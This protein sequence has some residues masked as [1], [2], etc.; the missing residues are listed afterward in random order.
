MATPPPSDDCSTSGKALR[1]QLSGGAKP[2]TPPRDTGVR[3]W[4]KCIVEHR[5]EP[6]SITWPGSPEYPDLTKF[7]LVENVDIFAVRQSPQMAT[8]WRDSVLVDYGSHASIRAAKHSRFPLLKL[9]HPQDE[10]SLELVQHEFSLLAGLASLDLPVVKV[11]QQPIIDNGAV[12]GYRMERLS[13]LDLAEFFARER[14]IR[15]ALVRLHA[16]GFSHGDVSPNNI[17]KDDDG[18]IVL[19][20]FGFARRIGDAV[21]PFIPRWVYADMIFSADS[22]WKALGRFTR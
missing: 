8:V 20:D 6:F 16:A 11:D 15:D 19:I 22:D 4:H 12:C 7:P 17:M 14:D 18:Q 21:P 3:G 10:Q 5:H 1:L 13:R 2:I 9:A